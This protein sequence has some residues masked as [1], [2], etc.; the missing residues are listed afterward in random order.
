MKVE[1]PPVEA[2]DAEEQASTREE[3]GQELTDLLIALIRQEE[4][5]RGEFQLTATFANE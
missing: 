5:L 4:L 3:L 2:H 1:L